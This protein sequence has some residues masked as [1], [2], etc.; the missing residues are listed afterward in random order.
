MKPILLIIS[1][2]VL[3]HSSIRAQVAIATGAGTPD[4]SAMLDIQSLNKGLLI[5]RMTSTERNNILLPADGLQVYDID[6]K[7]IWLYKGSPSNAWKELKIL[8]KV[9]FRAFTT[10]DQ[11]FT[12]SSSIIFGGEE[13]DE[14]N[15]F[16]SGSPFG[17]FTAPSAGVYSF[18]ANTT[19]N[20]S[21]VFY[22]VSVY[23]NSPG[24]SRP[25]TNIIRP[26][27]TGFDVST[28]LSF[29]LKLNTGD[30]LRIWVEPLGNA[31][32]KSGTDKT[33]WTGFKV[34]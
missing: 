5:P 23:L 33:W 22:Q 28:N 32:V 17:Y 12:S 21:G 16:T 30:I 24:S 26:P 9:A 11:L 10:S 2:I 6:T 31:T 18:Q 29:T 13:F 27:S 4:N 8:D 15:N 20:N 19:V 7:S 3:L 14:G 34:F 1:T 25:I